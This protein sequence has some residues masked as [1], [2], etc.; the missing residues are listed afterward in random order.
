MSTEEAG[1]GTATTFLE[2][3]GQQQSTETKG[4]EVYASGLPASYD[5]EQFRAVF[6]KFCTRGTISHCRFRKH[7]VGTQTGYGFLTFTDEQDGRD[8]I[9]G[10]NGSTLEGELVKVTDSASPSY[11]RSKT[12]LYIEGLPIDWDE[13]QVR[14][15][16]AQY[17]EITESRVLINRKTNAKTGVGFIHFK[18]TEEAESAITALNGSMASENSEKPLSIRFAKVMGRRRGGKRNRGRGRGGR[19]RGGQYGGFP[20][21]GYPVYQ[22]QFNPYMPYQQGYSA[23]MQPWGTGGNPYA[24]GYGPY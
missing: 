19:G 11:S 13:G 7:V 22:N 20:G 23:Y 5:E 12:N 18:T 21:Y 16:F 4:K 9:Q 14:K 1:T 24:R 17:G 6:E 3:G 8:A 10:M 2:E 15:L